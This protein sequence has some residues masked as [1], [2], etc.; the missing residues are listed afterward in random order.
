MKKDEEIKLLKQ[1]SR[2]KL[3][4]P[5]GLMKHVKT[6]MNN[7]YKRRQWY[8][9]TLEIWRD[10]LLLRTFAY[11]SYG[12]VKEVCRR[13]EGCSQVI[14]NDI[15]NRPLAGR[16]VEFF[17]NNLWDVNWFKR[18]NLYTASSKNWWFCEYDNLFNCEE[19]IEKLNIP[20]CCY[21]HP[22][23]RS[24]LCF[25]EYICI[26]RKY[27]KIELLVKAGWSNLVRYAYLFNLDGKTFKEAFGLDDYWKDYMAELDYTFIRLIKKYK[28]NDFEKIKEI[29]KVYDQRNKYINKHLNFKTAVFVSSLGNQKH[30]Y[31]DYLKFAE[32]IGLPL[33][34]PKYLYPKDIKKSH[35]EAYKRVNEIKDELVDKGI[36]DQA[37]KLSK[38]TYSSNQLF[39]FPASSNSELVKESKC[40]NHCVRTYAKRVADGETG[41]MLIRRSDEKEK[42]YYTL[43]LKGKR[44]VQIRGNHNSAPVPEVSEFV[45]QWEKKYRLTGY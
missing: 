18:G 43:E 33:N 45:R 21:H 30:L 41:I 31:N 20:Y 9:N 13:L 39:I 10:R 12:E 6:N 34:E 15:E 5:K 3:K 8:V 23:N 29:R 11:N 2:L 27:P 40:L 28:L 16:V 1:L 25:Y 44:I 38:Y 17:G 22:L 7:L 19:W 37:A 26:Y 35:D 14:L 4:V 42:P 36:A 32:E 24:G